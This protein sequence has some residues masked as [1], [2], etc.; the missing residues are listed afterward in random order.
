MKRVDRSI[1]GQPGAD[2][3]PASAGVLASEDTTI[4]SSIHTAVFTYGQGI[5]PQIR[6][7]C[8]FPAFTFILASEDTKPCSNIH[9]AVFRNR[10]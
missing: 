1:F 9:T 4:C 10:Q 3:F 8:S 7:A 5:N 6:Q 2:S